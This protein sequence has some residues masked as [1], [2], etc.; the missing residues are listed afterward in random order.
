[1]SPADSISRA[2][3]NKAQAVRLPRRLLAGSGSDGGSRRARMRRGQRLCLLGQA[4]RLQREV[5]GRFV[6]VGIAEQNH[7]RSRRGLANGGMVPY[8][9]GASCFL[10]ARAMEQIKVDLGYSKSN[11][12]SAG[13]RPGWRTDS[14]VR[15]ITPLKTSP[16]R[17]SAQSRSPRARRPDGDAAAM[18][19]SLDHHGPMFL[20]ISS[21]AGTRR[22]WG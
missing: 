14:S 2:N 1:M 16:G 21:H 6:N 10:T 11:V 19:Y 15:P 17:G 20:R 13:C 3:E 22:A 7:G 4:E 5:S 9:C 18:R 8:V 12:K